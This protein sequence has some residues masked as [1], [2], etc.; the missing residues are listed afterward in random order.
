MNDKAVVSYSEMER[1]AHS[2]VKSRMFGIDSVDQAIALM[3]VAV[4]E[5]KHP[6]IIARDFHVIQGKSAKKAEAMMRDM[7]AAGGKVEW[8]ELN[9]HV[10]DATFSHPAGGTVR[11]TWDM[12]RAKA[13]G[14]ASRE[15]WKK[16]PRAMLR[17]RCVSEGVRTVA[18]FA[19]SGVYTV[20]EVQ[21]IIIDERGP[22]I[23]PEPVKEERHEI[24][25]EQHNELLNGIEQAA[26][27]EELK[28][29]F[30]TAWSLAKRAQDSGRMLVYEAAKDER[31]D[32]L[33]VRADDNLPEVV[34]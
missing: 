3:S 1:L 19:T 2:I 4:A 25:L 24:T 34:S 31:K 13:A 26:D 11:I 30:S 20:E 6:G 18:P 12:E 10:A 29:A 27:L 8:H 16:Y 32:Y 14:L 33:L 22:S 5:G 17:S 28:R 21:D 9:D 23:E 15:N 7:C